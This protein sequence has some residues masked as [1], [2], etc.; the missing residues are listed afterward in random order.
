MLI[1]SMLNMS[2]Y[3]MNHP[4]HPSPVQKLFISWLSA[5]LSSLES[6]CLFPSTFPCFLWRSV[7]QTTHSSW[8]AL[9]GGWGG[10]HL[11]KQYELFYLFCYSTIF[12]CTHCGRRAVFQRTEGLW[13]KYWLCPEHLYYWYFSI[14]KIYW[15]FPSMETF[16]EDLLNKTSV[17]MQCVSKSVE[18]NK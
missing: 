11:S 13:N 8:S 10:R 2:K 1:V 9:T 17:V 6:D 15:C 14:Y 7:Q 4:S 16:R 3:L 12:H 5:E 18:S